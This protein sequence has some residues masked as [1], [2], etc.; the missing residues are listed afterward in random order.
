MKIEIEIAN[1]EITAII[2]TCKDQGI[3]V[4]MFDVKEQLE[5]WFHA[6]VEDFEESRMDTIID[7]LVD[8]AND[9]A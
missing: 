3:D 7:Q 6:T 5:E 9:P 4:T 2:E 1:E 8:L